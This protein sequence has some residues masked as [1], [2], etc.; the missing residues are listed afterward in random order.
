MNLPLITVLMPVFNGEKYLRQAIDSILNQSYSSF[1]FIIVNDGSTDNTEAIIRSYS[2]HRIKLINRSNGGVSAALNTGLQYASGKYIARMDSDDIAMPERLSVQ[3]DFMIN[4]VEYVLVGSDAEYIDEDGIFIFQYHN[5]GYTH[6]E[7][8]RVLSYDCAFLHSSVMFLKS[9]VLELGG[10]SLDAYLFE[11]YFLWIKLI[12]KGKFACI[13]QNLIA[14]RLNPSS[15]TIDYRDY[16][17]EYLRIKRQAIISGSI[18]ELEAVLLKKNVN[19]ISL[20]QK[21]FSYF[22]LLGKKYLWNNHQAKKARFFL[23]KA[24]RIKPFKFNPYLLILVSF[25]PATSISSLY[26]FIKKQY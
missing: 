17:K 16:S 1:E 15:I 25:L 20:A 5:S 6:E 22:S 3:L 9:A 23:L 11:D 8:K 13:K 10:Y 4:H 24:I 19:K 26:R 14:Y 18:S 7:I 12:N 2:D 21:R